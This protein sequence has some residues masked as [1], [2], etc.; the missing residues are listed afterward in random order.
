MG[1]ESR[2][3]FPIRLL[4]LP[5]L[6]VVH[7]DSKIYKEN[8]SYLIYYPYVSIGFETHISLFC[9]VIFRILVLHRYIYIFPLLLGI[10]ESSGYFKS[11]S[12]TICVVVAQKTNLVSS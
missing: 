1:E 5:T 12:Q 3:F 9:Y 4:M 8:I 10:P 2:D 6:S 7:K 11:R